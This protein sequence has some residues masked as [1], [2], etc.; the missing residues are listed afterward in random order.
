M[1]LGLEVYFI[2]NFLEQVNKKR[3]YLCS[4]KSIDKLSEARVEEPQG[5]RLFLLVPPSSGCVFHTSDYGFID[6]LLG[7]AS[8]SRQE[9]MER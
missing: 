5:C 3:G 7:I 8:K 6:P 2:H 1:E 9:K 4:H